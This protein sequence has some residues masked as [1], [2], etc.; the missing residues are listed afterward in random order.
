M[1]MRT[2]R[3]T[4][5]ATER[6]F[7]AA[8]RGI[9][10]FASQLTKTEERLL[11]RALASKTTKGSFAE[12]VSR[13]RRDRTRRRLLVEKFLT[14]PAAVRAAEVLLLDSLCDA[15]H[16]R[17][18]LLLRAQEAQGAA[19]SSLAGYLGSTGRP[20]ARTLLRARL[21]ELSGTIDTHRRNRIPERLAEAC[22]E[23]ASAL[24]RLDPD[25]TNAADVLIR[26]YREPARYGAC[27]NTVAFMRDVIV[28]YPVMQTRAVDRIR[29][30][31]RELLAPNAKDDDVEMALQALLRIDARRAIEIA[32]AHLH[33]ET[34]LRR[35]LAASLISMYS[36]A[37]EQPLLAY[38]ARHPGDWS[39]VRIARRLGSCV[40]LDLRCTLA[41]KQLAKPEPRDRLDAAEY[42]LE[43]PGPRATR[44]ATMAA[45]AEPDPLVAHVLRQR[46]A[47]RSR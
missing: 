20:G 26:M 15:P 13:F 35:A 44:I 43:T 8:E 36:S 24:L 2:T 29:E 31:L 34:G 17:K 12:A 41:E 39:V 46:C 10:P 14:F 45:A 47:P 9:E 7:V 23:T 5:S 16:V 40:P 19:F 33:S 27:M 18:E 38:L 42:L 3:R 11:A 4:F 21:R 25:A 32:E 30:T 37:P 22:A 1:A 6:V 28:S